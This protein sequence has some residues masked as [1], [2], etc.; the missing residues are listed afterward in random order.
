MS[1]YWSTAMKRAFASTMVLAAL[2]VVAPATAAAPN[3]RDLAF[4]PTAPCRILDTRNNGNPTPGVDTGPLTNGV[5]YAFAVRSLC[6]VPPDATV[7]MLNFVAF[8]ASAVGNLQAYPWESGPTFV[9]SASILNYN[10]VQNVANGVA[11]PLCNSA[12]ETCTFDLFARANGGSI[13]LIV[14]VLGWYA[15]PGGSSEAAGPDWGRG[16]P[17]VDRLFAC[18]GLGGYVYGLGN[19]KVSWGEA[20]AGCPAGTWVC[21]AEQ[22]GTA[23][24]NGGGDEACDLHDCAGTD[25]SDLGAN[26][27]VGWLADRASSGNG[28]ISSEQGAP[29]QLAMCNRVS[30]WCCSAAVPSN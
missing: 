13:H 17:G 23:V 28:T 9:P 16:R 11:L 19:T 20:A 22:R 8:G 4:T 3:Q 26:S 30:V 14:D 2:A 27:N 12:L 24:C 29:G 1:P 10:P 7:A 25:C 15:P 21:T 18:D 6:D 5:Q